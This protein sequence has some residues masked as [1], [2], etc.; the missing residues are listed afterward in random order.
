MSRKR[1]KRAISRDYPWIRCLRRTWVIKP[2][3]RV[4]EGS[5]FYD[6]QKVKLDMREELAV[7]LEERKR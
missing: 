3:D 5:K 2:F 1:G 4:Q 7:Y 6:R